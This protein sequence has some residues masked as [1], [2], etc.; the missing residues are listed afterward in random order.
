MVVLDAPNHLGDLDHRA[1]LGRPEGQL[2]AL[3][4]PLQDAASQRTAWEE[5]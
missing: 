4:A 5:E 3:G 1:R 2:A